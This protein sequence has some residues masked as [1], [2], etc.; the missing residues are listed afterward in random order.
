[1]LIFRIIGAQIWQKVWGPGVRVTSKVG[2]CLSS[3]L[4]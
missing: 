4:A 3:L 1:M 2:R